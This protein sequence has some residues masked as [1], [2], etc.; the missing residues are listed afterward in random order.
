[1][2]K[3]LKVSKGSWSMAGTKLSHQWLRDGKKIKK[4]TK[5]RYKL[6]K[7]DQGKKISVRVTA[8]KSGYKSAKVTTKATKKVKAK[9]AKK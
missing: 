7:K 9:K 1:M 5:P 4:A 6:T 8:K 3:T 2:G